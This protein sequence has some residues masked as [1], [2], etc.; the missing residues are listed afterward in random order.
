[1]DLTSL[2]TLLARK[3]ACVTLRSTDAELP[4]ELRDFLR[5]TPNEQLTLSIAASG[6]VLQGLTLTISGTS[7]DTWRV[8]G[9]TSII[10]KLS[11]VKIGITSGPNSAIIDATARATLILTSTAH[12][13]VVITT[14]QQASHPWRVALA[15]QAKDVAPTDLLLLAK[16]GGLPF[17]IPPGLNLLNTA[18]TVEPNKF[19]ITFYPNTAYDAWYE[20]QAKAPNAKWPLI[21]DIL[22]FDGIDVS[23][24]VTTS[25]YS[26]VLTGHLMVGGIAVDV[27]VN[28]SSGMNWVAFVRPPTGT[29]P[30]VAALISW[31]SGSGSRL[32]SETSSGFGSLHLDVDALNAAL[33]EVSVGFNSRTGTLNYLDIKS[34]LTV[35]GMPLDVVLRLPDISI[36]GNLHKRQ[37]IKVRNVLSSFGLAANDVPDNLSI[38]AVAF[39]ARIRERFYSVGITVDNVWQVGPLKL[40]EISAAVSYFGVMGFAGQFNCKLGLG[41]AA[42]FYLESRYSG[43]G[44][45]WQFSGGVAAPGGL[46]I[47]DFLTGTIDT[48]F[49]SVPPSK[50]TVPPMLGAVAIKTLGV[51]FNTRTKDF[52]FHAEIDFSEDH[53]V[54]TILTFSELHQ[55]GAAAPTFEKRATGVIT[56]FPGDKDKEFAFDLAI[57]IKPNSRH[58]VALYNNAAGKGINLGDLARQMV[59]GAQGIADFEITI[60]DAIVGY[61]SAKQGDKTN[62]CAIFA[63]DLGASI[64]LS[65]LGDI[66]LVGQSLSAAKTLKLALQLVYPT[67]PF[68]KGDLDALNKLI[69]V[70]GPRFPADKDLKDLFVKMELRLGDGAPINFNAP[71]TINKSNGELQA[72]DSGGGGLDP[73]G[74]QATDDGVTWIQLDEKFGPLHLQRAGFKLADGAIT[75]L[76][77]GGLTALGL[78]VDLM[79]L[80]VTSTIT[81]VKDGKFDPVFGLQ[82]LGISFAKGGVAI[83]GALLHRKV[84]QADGR[85]TDKYDGLATVQAGALRLA[86]IGSLTTVGDQPSLFVYAVLDYPLGGSPFFYVTGLAGGFG[87]NRKLVMPTVDQVKDFPLIAAAT[88]P[89]KA[90]ALPADP[91]KVGA[92]IADRMS[93][94]DKHLT[95]DLGQY[96]GCAGVRFTSFKLLDSFVLVSLSF[97]REFELDLLGVSTLVAPPQPSANTPP[98][99]AITL[100]IAASFIPD[101]G[102]AI[103]QGQLT[104][105]SHI[106]DPNCRLTGG[107]A[108]AAWF[109]RN[110]HAGD[111]V[112]TLGGYHPAFRKPAHYPS[113]PRI[114]VNWQISP[115]LSV[116]GG[117]YF[118]LTPHALMAGGALHATFHTSFDI[119]VASVDVKAWFILGADFIVYWKPF[120]YNAEVYVEIGID[121]VIHFLGTHDIGLDA[122]AELDVWGPPFGGRA[123]VS[124]TV[125]GITFGFNIA[126]GAGAPA[127]PPLVWD[128]ATDP[129]QSFRQSFLPADTQIV[130]VAVAGGLVRK[131]D[132][133]KQLWQVIDPE[134]LRMHT[135]SAVPIKSCA[136]KLGWVEKKTTFAEFGSNT[137]FGI[138]PMRKRTADVQTVH[139]VEVKRF[140]E[141]GDAN[142]EQHFVLRPL[143]DQVPGALWA[144]HDA[145]D[146][147]AE[148]LVKNAA[149]GFE[150][151]PRPAKAPAPDKDCK[152]KRDSLD[153]AID[154]KTDAY[155]DSPIKAFAR[156][157]DDPGDDA[158]KNHDL[159]QRIQR[160]IH[161]SEARA[162]MLEDMGFTDGEL[163]IGES[164]CTDAAYAPRYGALVT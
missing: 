51:D 41:D 10:A 47:S 156:S 136:T 108:F 102:L 113:V 90:P 155:A 160:E 59:P 89:Q 116:T 159:W 115:E 54:R 50:T 24:F 75:A 17:D 45:G 101:Q 67:A 117:L 128:S 84:R 78:E 25:V 7:S 23:A 77:D 26:V 83:D 15:E 12:L 143:C 133:G 139:H 131:I 44:A 30:S 121:V 49:P 85:E 98:L 18:L 79:G 149:T 64:D 153:D 91:G 118:A 81:G 127:A 152:L 141:R 142:P 42:S 120:R 82:G 129:S 2:K 16:G 43:P 114:G 56:V 4:Q 9:M 144:G 100:Q 119:G 148:R 126:F 70:A 58:F 161:A 111:F 46:R 21:T 150:I 162:A 65:G 38:T 137:D 62:S 88:D 63:L 69:T 157:G 106:L 27:G 94:L 5:T 68:A 8:Q 140:G 35:G 55:Q 71:I 39:A 112:V 48:L 20:F 154:C 145:A 53:D 158:A 74:G 19:G 110:E 95:P 36:V 104:R 97:G 123:H 105:E 52:D 11:H 135:H 147:N 72:P 92:F 125:I 29:F 134:H 6:I 28:L 31:V 99:A 66:P 73:T 40:E 33:A 32:A 14:L 130:A 60:Q 163:D 107:F 13:P 76:L 93:A 37:P 57:D 87:L 109:G 86:A 146:I 96:F 132:D 124:L 138:A 22:S 3:G 122:A 61:T 164:F 151:V 103:M 80:S 34:L 1:M